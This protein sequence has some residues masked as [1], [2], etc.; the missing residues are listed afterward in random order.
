[1]SKNAADKAGQGDNKVLE[2]AKAP[3]FRKRL[4]DRGQ[5]QKAV[6]GLSIVSVLVMTVFLNEWIVKSQTSVEALAGSNRGIASFEE[7]SSIESIQWEHEL[8]Q[9][10]AMEKDA[11]NSLLAAKPTLKDELVFGFLEGKYK[12][13]LSNNKIQSFEF[14]EARTNEQPLVIKQKEEFLKIFKSVFSVNYAKV[15]LDRKQGK[16][17]V[18][19]L[20]SSSNQ[21]LGVAQ[22]DL[23]DQ[24]RVLALKIL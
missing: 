4:M 24:G 11:A 3:S 6:L 12:T 17:E 19:R 23:D 20:L 14:S 18:Y 21:S 5:D 2:F 1:M 13:R 15:Q 16:Q 7:N 8:A 22:F 9:K 10:L